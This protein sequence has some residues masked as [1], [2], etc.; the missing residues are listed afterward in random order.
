MSSKRLTEERNKKVLPLKDVVALVDVRT[1]EGD[2]AGKVFV[3]MLKGLGAK[4]H[5][6][7]TIPLTH[8]IFKAGKQTTIDKWLIHPKPKPSLVGIGWVV[9]CREILG[10]A[11]ETPYIIDINSTSAPISDSVNLSKS[12]GINSTSVGVS[13]RRKSMEPKALALLGHG[14]QL[15][16]SHSRGK[17]SESCKGW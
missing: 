16:Q 12:L 10:K 15:N 7:P 13:N 9:R 6:R 4:V 1:A 11:N 3:E 14:L 17:L 2:D 8:I 5:L